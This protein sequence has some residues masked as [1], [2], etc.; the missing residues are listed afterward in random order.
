MVK[1]RP[2]AI[3]APALGAKPACRL[4]AVGCL[5][6]LL[7]IKLECHSL[8]VP[9]QKVTLS[10]R[11]QRIFRSQSAVRLAKTDMNMGASVLHDN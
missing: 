11:L 5:E 3:A 8:P 4:A 1:D 6:L 10:C 2:L 9:T 7:Q